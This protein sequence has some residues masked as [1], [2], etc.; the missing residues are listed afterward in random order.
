MCIYIYLHIDIDLMFKF[1]LIYIQIEVAVTRLWSVLSANGCM[2]GCIIYI[3]HKWCRKYQGVV[4]FHTLFVELV[5]INVWNRTYFKEFYA[6]ILRKWQKNLKRKLIRAKC[7][8]STVG[9]KGL[10]GK[11]YWYFPKIIYF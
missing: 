6:V 8:V 4:E 5:Q 11:K 3:S 7:L 1:A 10:R 2:C 9:K